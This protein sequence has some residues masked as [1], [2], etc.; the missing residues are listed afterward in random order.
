MQLSGKYEK[1]NRKFSC[2]DTDFHFT[3]SPS[4]SKF[5]LIRMK[6]RFEENGFK[7]LSYYA[8]PP[9]M[10]VSINRGGKAWEIL[11]HNILTT[12]I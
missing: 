4:I 11:D 10:T 3:F 12:Y 5:I 6:Q 2:R 8:I 9:V 7:R 1:T